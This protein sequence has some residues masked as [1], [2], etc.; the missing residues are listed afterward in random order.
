[1][2]HPKLTAA[3]VLLAGGALVAGPLTVAS[4]AAAIGKAAPAARPLSTVVG[5][6]VSVPPGGHGIATAACPAGKIVSGG[7]GTT[8]AFDIEFTDSTTSGN[9]WLI[10]G[11]NHGTTAQTL[12]ASAV[13]LGLS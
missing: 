3:A 7:G 1:M 6:G 2:K 9:G 13:C 8:S 11:T 4:S 5:P 12:T 10:R